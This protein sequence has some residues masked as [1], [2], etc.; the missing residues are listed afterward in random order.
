MQN[1]INEWYRCNNWYSLDSYE[2][3][4]DY[5]ND[6]LKFDIP[7]AWHLSIMNRSSQFSYNTLDMI[8]YNKI[9]GSMSYLYT[10]K[11]GLHIDNSIQ[12]PLQNIVQTMQW[13]PNKFEQRKNKQSD[14]TDEHSDSS[15]LYYG[16]LYYPTAKLEAMFLHNWYNKWQIVTRWIS[17][18]QILSNWSITLRKQNASNANTVQEWCYSNVD[19]LFG[20]RFLHSL[21]T[22]PSR[23]NNSLYMNSNLSCGAEFWL[24]GN[25]LNPGCSTTLRYLT[26]S[27]NTGRPIV[28]LLSWNP[29]FG[30]L[31]TSYSAHV[32]KNLKLGTRYDFN[33][34]SLQSNLSLGLEFWNK[35][36]KN[37]NEIEK[38]RNH[39][40][41]LKDTYIPT[42][43]MINQNDK[44][45][46]RTD[47]D[48]ITYIFQNSLNQIDNEKFLINNFKRNWV[49]E[50]FNSVWKLSTSLLEKDI[51]LLWQGKWNGFILSIGTK[52]SL[53]T[54]QET[55][56]GI[57]IQ[58]I[59]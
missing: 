16:R 9:I 49:N 30:H 37:G 31:A 42:Q 54:L 35:S 46:G 59:N 58:Y 34:Y 26:H 2:N 21:R 40:L 32:L 15:S 53:N 23:F 57:K 38:N 18:P 19:S 4:W 3:V 17:D 39:H 13:F 5:S 56:I 1:I 47:N 14:H 44:E 48:Y 51:N 55:K 28:V 24:S 25:T 11:A 29:I 7:S 27:A 41:S 50:K 33:L 36:A 10:D 52:L 8:R 43:I 20:Y 22:T 6:L 12:M 45:F